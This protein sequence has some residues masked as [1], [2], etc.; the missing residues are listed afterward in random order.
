M[1]ERVMRKFFIFMVA[2]A[3][4]VASTAPV[5]ANDEIN[6]AIDGRIRFETWSIDEDAYKFKY[7]SG[8]FSDRETE[9]DM[10]GS[11]IR[12]KGTYGPLLIGA[13]HNRG[14]TTGDYWAEWDFGPGKLYMGEFDPPSYVTATRASGSVWAAG[15]PRS[16]SDDGLMMVRW[17]IGNL[18]LKVAL[19]DPD[20]G[21][22]LQ[23]YDSSYGMTGDLD[24][25]FPK[26]EISAEFKL[27]MFD[28]YG[29]YGMHS[30]DEVWTENDREMS[31]DSNFYGLRGS[32]NFGP[33]TLRALYWEAE[34]AKAYGTLGVGSYWHCWHKG[35]LYEPED[36]GWEADGEWKVNDKFTLWAGYASRTSERSVPDSKPESDKTDVYYVRGEYTI[37]KYFTVYPMFGVVD[38]KDR[39]TDEGKIVQE[40]KKK[41]IGARWQIAF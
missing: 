2:A 24:F 14:G 32:V 17:P 11:R 38:Y 33:L 6:W 9:W 4:V 16:S 27:G 36:D 10:G 25:S 23:I 7:G 26:I 19:I 21:Q 35:V 5:M 20:N 12:F 3:F 31:I 28:L 30:Y 39:I 34:N 18:D 15:G 40:G 41:W 37:T 29:F 22:S 1:E 13:N 8:K